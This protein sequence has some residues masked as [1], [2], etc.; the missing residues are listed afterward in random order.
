MWSYLNKHPEHAA[1]GP[2]ALLRL[3]MS[4]ESFKLGEQ[5]GRQAE[6]ERNQK[7][8]AAAME[9]DAQIIKDQTPSAD[10]DVGK[11]LEWSRKHNK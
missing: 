11:I 10:W 4:S 2:V 1:L 5:Q 7:L 6:V 8:K 3:A 9:G